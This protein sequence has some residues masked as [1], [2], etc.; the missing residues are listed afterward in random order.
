MKPRQIALYVLGSLITLCFFLVLSLLIFRGIPEQNS[1]VLYLA[2]GALI[3]FMSSV[4]GYF[5][6]SS[7]GSADKNEML[8][9]KDK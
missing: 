9:P 5:Y 2:I 3:G 7:M 4:V 8:K 6:G 1:D